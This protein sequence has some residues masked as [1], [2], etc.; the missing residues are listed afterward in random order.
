VVFFSYGDIVIQQDDHDDD[1]YFIIAGEVDVALNGRTVSYREAPA[2]VGEMAARAPGKKRSATIRVCSDEMAAM[3]MPG[4]SFRSMCEAN[5][6]FLDRLEVEMTSRLREQ[7]AARQ[8]L[9][10]SYSNSWALISA[11]VGFAAALVAFF[12]SPDFLPE[13]IKVPFSLGTGLIAF[14][15]ILAVNPAFF[16]RR[17]FWLCLM[18][19]PASLL[20]DRALTVSASNSNNALAL[21][22][23][24]SQDSTLYDTL[25]LQ[26]FFLGAMIIC[27]IKD[28]VDTA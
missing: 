15:A 2:Q 19:G 24:I 1:V 9:G 27:A 7:L 23:G 22:V 8:A 26:V 25:S 3:K 21:S 17:C 14:V 13:Q 6:D 11:A 18:A 10:R 4:A 12:F 5:P 20:L 16:W 28:R